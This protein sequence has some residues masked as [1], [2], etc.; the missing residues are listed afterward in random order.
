MTWTRLH[1][2]C[3]HFAHMETN[4]RKSESNASLR[5]LWRPSS[6]GRLTDGRPFIPILHA[7]PHHPPI[8]LRIDGFHQEIFAHEGG[9]A[10]LVLGFVPV[11]KPTEA[12]PIHR[13]RFDHGKYERTVE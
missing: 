11:L 9:E 8:E 3:V 1:G 2:I 4:S 13:F 5:N 12:G 10:L 7:R 6:K